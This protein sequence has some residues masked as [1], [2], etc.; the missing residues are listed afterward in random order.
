M[1]RILKPAATQTRYVAEYIVVSMTEITK[2]DRKLTHPRL[3][4]AQFE[5]AA[6]SSELHSLGRSPLKAT[7]SIMAKK[8]LNSCGAS[9]QPCF[10]PCKM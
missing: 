9:T 4:M 2:D 6:I 1:C 5:D 8:M 7:S 10:V 3:E